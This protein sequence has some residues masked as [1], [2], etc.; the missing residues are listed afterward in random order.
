[1]KKIIS[2]AIL[3]FASLLTPAFG[4]TVSIPDPGLNAA[5]RNALQIPTAPLTEQD[6]LQLRN[7][8]ASRRNVK[9]AVGLDSARNLVSLNLQINQL[10]NF[11][12]PTTLTNLLVLDLTANP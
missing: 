5:V 3:A 9:S 1:M 11:S 7:L 6:L 8:D 2:A 12:I 10:T 4:Q